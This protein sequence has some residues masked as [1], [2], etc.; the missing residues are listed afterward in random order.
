MPKKI[1][2]VPIETTIIDIE[3]N[4]EQ[5]NTKQDANIEPVVIIEPDVN[6]EPEPVKETIEPQTQTQT[7]EVVMQF[8]EAV[9]KDI[10]KP[11]KRK[12]EKVYENCPICNKSMLKKSLKY[13][14]LANC[15]AKNKPK[16]EVITVQEHVAPEPVNP[17]PV[18]P[19]PVAP[20]PVV[21][22][23]R[24]EMME[25]RK[26]ELDLRRAQ[27]QEAVKKLISKAF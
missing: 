26:R 4:I 22:S 15:Q 8:L 7:P 6:V 27:K 1:K 19:E 12:A 24:E 9:N 17:T 3:D 25:N 23:A 18:A 5:Q 13:N 21:K 16:E 2:V 11:I 20:A 10:D 14:H